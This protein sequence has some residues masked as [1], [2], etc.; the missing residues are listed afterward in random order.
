MRACGPR[1]SIDHALELC[2]SLFA[3]T[4]AL[5][6]LVPPCFIAL[7]LIISYLAMYTQDRLMR[8]D[9]IFSS[10]APQKEHGL[11]R[12]SAV[13]SAVDRAEFGAKKVAAG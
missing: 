3:V 1:R 13:Q 5:G 8:D 6:T 12:R 9:A 10:P 2:V 4:L 7:C 11:A